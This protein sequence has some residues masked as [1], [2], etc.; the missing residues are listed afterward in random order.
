MGKSPRLYLL[1]CLAAAAV[2]CKA[3]GR[4]TKSL[5]ASPWKFHK[6]VPDRHDITGQCALSVPGGDTRPLTDGDMRTAWTAP[7]DGKPVL[8]VT[9]GNGVR[10]NSIVC[11][12]ADTAIDRV[13]LRLEAAG[14]DGKWMNIANHSERPLKVSYRESESISETGSTVG[15]VR[16][17]EYAYIDESIYKSKNTVTRLYTKARITLIGAQDKDGRSLPL[18]VSELEV[19]AEGNVPLTPETAAAPGFDDSSWETV[20]VPHCYNDMDTYLNVSDMRMWKGEA[21]Y[22]RKFSVPRKHSGK[23]I[24][25]R[26]DGVNIA[27]AVY[28]NGHFVKGNTAVAQPGD[29]TSVGGFIPFAVDI[30]EYVR[31]GQDNTLAVRVSNA[32]NSFF[33]GPGFGEFAPFGMGWG[34]IVQPV[35][36]IVTGDVHIPLDC[37]S[38]LGKWGTYNATVAAS[39]SEARLRFQTR[40]DNDGAKAAYVTLH[41]QLLDSAGREVASA[42]SSRKIKAAGTAVFDES[43]TVS[44]PEL[45]YPNNS[46]YGR[47][48]LYTVVRTVTRGGKTTDSHSA[49]FGIRTVSWDNDY[50][51]INGKKHLLNGFGYRNV[52]PALGSAVP[53]ELQWN[54]MRLLAAC[55]ANTLRVGHVPPTN[56]MLDACDEYGIMVLLNSGDNEWSL[57]GEPTCTYKAE[58]D[59]NAMVAFRNHTSVIVWESNNGIARSKDKYLP[60]RTQAA[61]DVWD[62]IQH[63]AV[64]NRDREMPGWPEGKP[65]IVGYTN[66]YAKVEGC[67]SINTEVYGANWEGRAS[68]NAARFDYDNEKKLANWYV[69][70]YLDDIGN[71]ACGWIDWM[72]TETQGEGYTIHLN[73]KRNQKSLGSSAL[74]AN[75][76]P[77][78]KYRIYEKAL[79]MP[80]GKKPGVALQSHWNLSGIQ[81]VDAWSNCPAVEMTLNG[82][83]YGVRT[84]DARTRRCRWDNIV[85]QPGTVVVRGLDEQKRVVCA[86]SIRTAGEPHA[87]EL[88]VEPPLT[89]PAGRTFARTANGSDAIIITARVVDKDG[90][91]CPLYNGNI[92][93]SVEGEG[94]YK[95]S[96]DFYIT[97]GQAPGYHAPGDHELTAEGGLLR[98]AVR[99]TFKPGEIRVRAT[100][101]GLKDGQVSYSTRPLAY[102]KEK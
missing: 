22:R 97:D 11:K 52:Y 85:W 46:P 93:F 98:V 56:E 82:K 42:R 69:D 3:S 74:D 72:L 37:Y 48:Y 91:W 102:A 100:A 87:I 18:S 71:K 49:R 1:A 55:G 58:Y 59:R 26:F 50:C 73:G 81:D 70:N 15:H 80:Y 94:V 61:A 44:R 41:T 43:L 8:E 23:R 75:R 9:A 62:S 76:F 39:D 90:V 96:A 67:P 25:L 47:P 35:R 86:D 60:Q 27:T 51:Y 66:K 77:K 4:E 54:D 63:R 21:W 65:Q 13:F 30:T 89:T 6:M 40:V 99:S 32:P 84:P 29:V 78:L 31:P 53:A 45:W 95:G 19:K 2:V 92:T 88:T 10:M 7:K 36:L 57:K 17:K 101:D 12:F 64:L 79:W 20:G 83:S 34:G 33:T 28:V 16:Q 5:C 38:A 14:A 24:F 68:W